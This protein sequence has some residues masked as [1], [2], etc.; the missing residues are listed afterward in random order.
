MN[1][2]IND[3]LYS[4]DSKYGEK[5]ITSDFSSNLLEMRLKSAFCLVFRKT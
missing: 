2:I 5:Q 4:A 1:S 3:D